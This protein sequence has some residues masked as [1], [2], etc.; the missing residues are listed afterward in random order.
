[1]VAAAALDPLS[2]EDRERCQGEAPALRAR[3][4]FVPNTRGDPRSEDKAAATL[5]A[6]ASGYTLSWQEWRAGGREGHLPSP[7]AGKD[8]VS[9]ELGIE[10]LGPAW[11]SLSPDFPVEGSRLWDQF[12]TPRPNFQLACLEKQV[13]LSSLT[14]THM[15]KSMLV[16][17]TI[18]T[19]IQLQSPAL[20]PRRRLPLQTSPFGDV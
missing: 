13:M 19:S 9:R 11:V 16:N 14:Q 10:R 3:R 7:A 6:D 20:R 2:P 1:M 4:P 12:P 15:S 17:F 18:S 8:L 5:S